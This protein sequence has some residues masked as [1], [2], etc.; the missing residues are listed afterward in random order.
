MRKQSTV[1][2][3]CRAIT[4]SLL[5]RREE[6]TTFLK[7]SIHADRVHV[8]CATT[9]SRY[10]HARDRLRVQEHHTFD[11]VRTDSAASVTYVA[12]LGRNFG[13]RRMVCSASESRMK[14]EL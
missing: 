7:R 8:Y 14:Y 4:K 6:T 1:D 5:F 13:P 11:C 3:G 10:N 9:N 2:V 12:M